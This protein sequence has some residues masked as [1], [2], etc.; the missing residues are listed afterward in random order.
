MSIFP[1]VSTESY[2]DRPETSADKKSYVFD[3]KKGEFVM[4]D[5]KN[6]IVTG[7]ERIKVWIEKL[8]RTELG[9]Y[10]IYDGTTYGVRFPTSVI[11]LRD[12]DYI[13]DAISSELRAKLTEN[14]EI[15]DVRE[16]TVNF[17]RAAVYVSAAVI[18]VYDGEEITVEYYR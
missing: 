1:T 18:T 12:R 5:G 3:F 16:I 7:N 14:E 2:T 4:R 17:E 15:T 6:V 10:P 9:R 11:G 8:I 13:R